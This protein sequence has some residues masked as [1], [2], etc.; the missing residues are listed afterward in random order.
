MMMSEILSFA[1]ALLA[2]ILLGGFFYGGLWWTVRTGV[3]SER[4]ALWFLGSLVLR[5]GITLFGFYLI[6]GGRWQHMLVC[7]LG[8]TLGRPGV[9][10]LTAASQEVSH[11][12]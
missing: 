10:R 7:L 4:P 6:G 3:S 11:A 2:G 1:P 9:A 5:M 12:S 8:F